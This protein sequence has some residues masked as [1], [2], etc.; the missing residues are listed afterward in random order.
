MSYRNFLIVLTIILSAVTAGVSQSAPPQ[1][2]IDRRPAITKPAGSDR[3]VGNAPTAPRR[4]PAKLQTVSFAYAPNL[5]GARMTV[6]NVGGETA[7]GY[8]QVALHA[9]KKISG[10]WPSVTGKMPTSYRVLCPHSWKADGWGG[11]PPALTG[12][13]H[14]IDLKAGES[15]TMNIKLDRLG[16]Y[17]VNVHSS[18]VDFATQNTCG[19]QLGANESW[20]DY[21][22]FITVH[23]DASISNFYPFYEAVYLNP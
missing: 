20:S 1:R 9:A 17:K 11:K 22:Y 13:S 3:T 21:K 14:L 16:G 23:S 7:G 4:L 6:K 10:A 19:P 5:P 8:F 15:L 12:T 18:L 2:D